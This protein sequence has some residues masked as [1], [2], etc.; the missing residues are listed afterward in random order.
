MKKIIAIITGIL[1]LASCGTASRAVDPENDSTKESI[2]K[3][4]GQVSRDQTT[5]AVSKAKL[6]ENDAQSYTNLYD[7]IRAKLPGVQV[8]S[9]NKLLIRGVN[10]INASTD[11][12]ILVDGVEIGD[13]STLSPSEVKSMEVIKDGTAAIY[14]V[15]GANGVILITTKGGR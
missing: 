7:Y 15:R 1:T 9:G 2:N 8:L 11:P 12:L 5:G 4:Y 10:S 3:G 13:I 14:G 6:R